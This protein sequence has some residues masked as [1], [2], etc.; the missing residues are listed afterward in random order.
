[1]QESRSFWSSYSVQ[2]SN[3]TIFSVIAVDLTS[4]F[5]T[6]ADVSKIDILLMFVD[7]ILVKACVNPQSR[8]NLK[9]LEVASTSVY[10]GKWIDTILRYLPNLQTN[11]QTQLWPSGLD[12]HWSPT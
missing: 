11:L 8:R 12:R 6:E 4:K 9:A 7:T 10:V 2:P 1:M 3:F 5:I